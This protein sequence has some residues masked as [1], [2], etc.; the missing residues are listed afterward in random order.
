M[1]ISTALS[2]F[3]VMSCNNTLFLDLID[4][5]L[6][7]LAKNSSTSTTRTYIQCV[8]AIRWDTPHKN[9]P[10]LT[11]PQTSLV[12]NMYLNINHNFELNKPVYKL[13]KPLLM[14][15][16]FDDLWPSFPGNPAIP[17]LVVSCELTSVSFFFWFQSSSRTQVWGAF[18]E[19]NATHHQVLSSRGRWAKRVLSTSL[20]IIRQKMS[21]RDFTFCWRCTYLVCFFLTAV[22]LISDIRTSCQLKLIK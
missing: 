21:K 10:T 3:L 19:D 18:R 11:G 12:F 6:S 4:F 14:R 15:V 17:S 16:V 7:E 8:G 2:G 1:H 13:I 9:L 5:L 22:K 20:R